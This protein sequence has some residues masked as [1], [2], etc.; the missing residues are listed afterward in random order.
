[1]GAP[2]VSMMEVERFVTKLLQTAAD[3]FG[4]CLGSGWWWV[5]LGCGSFSRSV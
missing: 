1:M 2:K 5:V 4:T 3:T